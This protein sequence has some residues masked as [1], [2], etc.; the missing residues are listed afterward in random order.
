ML[1][2]LPEGQAVLFLWQNAHTV[3]IGSGQNA[4]RE[5]N[6]ALLEKEIGR[7]HV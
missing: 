6:T 1:L 5:C 4:W 3:V 2:S 7:A